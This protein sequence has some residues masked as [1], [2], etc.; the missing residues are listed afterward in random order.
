[1]VGL[2]LQNRVDANLVPGKNKKKSSNCL[3]HKQKSCF[4][5]LRYRRYDVN[6]RDSSNV[7]GV[8]RGDGRAVAKLS[9]A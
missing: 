9:L 8:T 1:M 3:R 4:C 5:F 7:R 6:C 2:K